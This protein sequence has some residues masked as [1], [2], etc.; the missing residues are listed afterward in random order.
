MK[1]ERIQAQT[2]LDRKYMAHVAIMALKNAYKRK[3]TYF[4]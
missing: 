4:T 3:C 1:L 2:N